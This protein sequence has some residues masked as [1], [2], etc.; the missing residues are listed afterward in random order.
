MLIPT[1]YTYHTRVE[2]DCRFDLYPYATHHSGDV[3]VSL[4]KVIGDA[5][6]TGIMRFCEELQRVHTTRETHPKVIEIPFNSTNKYQVCVGIGWAKGWLV[7]RWWGGREGGR[8]WEGTGKVSGWIVL[9][10]EE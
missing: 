8:R 10:V 2:R 4:R 7:L 6:E 5:S 3:P 9:V 1:Q